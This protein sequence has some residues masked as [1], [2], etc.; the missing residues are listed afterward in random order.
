M[1]LHR[2]VALSL[3]VSQLSTGALWAAPTNSNVT[4]EFTFIESVIAL[5][6]QNLKP[7][8]LDQQLKSVYSTYVSSAAN[9]E[10]GQQ[11]RL[12][13]ALIDLGVYTPAQAN[14][15]VADAANATQSLSSVDVKGADASQLMSEFSALAN[16]HPM[17]A[18]FSACDIL[19]ANTAVGVGAMGGFLMAIAGYMAYGSDQGPIYSPTQ[20]YGAAH[21]ANLATARPTFYAGAAMVGVAA[22]VITY[23]TLNNCSSDD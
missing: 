3:I 8:D 15:F 23:S 12:T 14:G 11:Q 13:Q 10:D 9:A 17:G 20:K 1:K 18:Q 22:I 19:S 2:S 16:L 5:Q 6:G 21:D 4:P 7:T